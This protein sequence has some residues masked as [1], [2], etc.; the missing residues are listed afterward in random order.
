MS[1]DQ[2][3][4]IVAI[5]AMAIILSNPALPKDLFR[6]QSCLDQGGSLRSYEMVIN[7]KRRQ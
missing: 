3:P 6:G 2:L 4:F 7:S 5:I 1:V